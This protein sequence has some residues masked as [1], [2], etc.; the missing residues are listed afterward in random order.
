MQYNGLEDNKA[1]KAKGFRHVL[2]Y[3]RCKDKAG[4]AQHFADWGKALNKCGR[5]YLSDPETL[6]L[7][8]I[9]T[10]PKD[11]GFKCP[12]KTLKFPT[13]QC[14]VEYV[15]NKTEGQRQQT[16]ADALYVKQN[17]PKGNINALGER[18][19]DEQAQAKPS[20]ADHIASV[21]PTLEHLHN[22]MTH[23]FQQGKGG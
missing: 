8:L 11:H 20:A 21:M 1:V 9:G 10:P 13:W 2:K 6:H 14:I 12:A 17:R 4:L 19:G 3:P 18:Q 16:I 5:Q 23:A 7:M 15:K 22:M